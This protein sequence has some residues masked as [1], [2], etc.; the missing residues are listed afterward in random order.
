MY[1]YI[2][3]A[4]KIL[5]FFSVRE[6]WR[7]QYS[8]VQYDRHQF[9]LALHCIVGLEV[10]GGFHLSRCGSRRWRDRIY[11]IVCKVCSLDCLLHNKPLL[12]RYYNISERYGKYE[13]FWAQ[14]EFHN[15]WTSFYYISSDPVYSKGWEDPLQTTT[16]V[17]PE[18]KECT[19]LYFINLFN[20]SRK[21]RTLAVDSLDAGV[22]HVLGA[23]L[24]TLGK[25]E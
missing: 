15:Y 23:Y 18:S 17:T 8:T 9:N 3:R 10:Y 6:L 20:L 21:T 1:T 12:H 11:C 22:P 14:I 24:G 7:I 5:P 13:L 25:I 4:E 2:Y 16:C 19:L